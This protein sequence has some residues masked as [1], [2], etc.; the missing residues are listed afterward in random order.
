MPD[1]SHALDRGARDAVHVDELLL[2]LLRQ[3]LERVRHGE[4]ALARP[5]LEEARAACP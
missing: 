5:A 3:R 4:L 1:C 2:F